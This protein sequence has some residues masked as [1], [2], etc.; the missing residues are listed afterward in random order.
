MLRTIK[1]YALLVTLWGTLALFAVAC[2]TLA[3]A[4]PEAGWSPS[5]PTAVLAT[6]DIV[7]EPVRAQ[8]ATP[9]D[10]PTALAPTNTPRPTPS[11]RA[12]TPTPSI[13]INGISITRIVVLSEAVRRHI[14]EVFAQGQA[15]G[16]NPRAFSKVG[17]ST[18]VY[19][20]FLA[21]FD[22]KAYKLGTFSSLQ[23]TIDRFA[24]SFGRES[25]AAKK[26]MHTWSEFDPAWVNSNRCQSNEGPLACELRL[27][28]P[29][30][31]LIRLGANDYYAPQEFNTQLVKIVETCL[32]DGVIPVL[33]TKPDRMEGQAN[34]LNK[35]IAQIAST[36]ALPLWDYDLIVGT[37]PGKGL[38]KDGVHFVGSSSRDY[39]LTQTFQHG[40]ALED[41]TGLWML[42][43][44]RREVGSTGE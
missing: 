33:G 36:Y 31:A 37:I 28:N 21:A 42:D 41:L 11:P 4:P 6:A 10:T 24:G 13:N 16:R 29:S 9:T 40:D 5:E 39:A 20:P 25:I 27:N 23:A 12:S 8:I 32:A 34:T 19:P 3:E 18:M 35:T 14:H 2:S 7:P 44:I 22:G 15:R 30:I 38:E 43:A 17:D 26:G 1:Q